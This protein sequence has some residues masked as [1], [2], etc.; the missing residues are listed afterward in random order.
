MAGFDSRVRPQ[1]LAFKPSRPSSGHMYT[2]VPLPTERVRLHLRGQRTALLRCPIDHVLTAWIDSFPAT[3]FLKPSFQC[4][5][6]RY[7]LRS[8]GRTLSF[9]GSLSVC[10]P[11]MSIMNEQHDGVLLFLLSRTASSIPAIDGWAILAM[12]RII[13]TS[14]VSV[15][16]LWELEIQKPYYFTGG[17]DRGCQP[18]LRI[19]CPTFPEKAH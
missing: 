5:G 13:C 4:C 19:A 11:W 8:G 1:A 14:L 7:C 6:N 9:L 18:D 15:C 2:T 16:E 10:R 12:C 3:P 17:F